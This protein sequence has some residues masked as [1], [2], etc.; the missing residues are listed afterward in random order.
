MQR[1]G[2]SLPWAMK[3]HLAIVSLPGT[4]RC[5]IWVRL[6]ILDASLESWN[7][8]HSLRR[9]KARDI[10]VAGIWRRACGWG[11]YCLVLH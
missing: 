9:A 8:R 3:D 2:L 6:A 4:G 5:E 7:G 11:G 1:Q 10:S